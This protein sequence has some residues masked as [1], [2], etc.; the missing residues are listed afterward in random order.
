LAIGSQYVGKFSYSRSTAHW[1]DHRYSCDDPYLLWWTGYGSVCQTTESNPDRY[2]CANAHG[3]Y[4]IHYDRNALPNIYCFS[5]FGWSNRYTDSI[6]HEAANQ[7]ALAHGIAYRNSNTNGHTNIYTNSECH[8]IA[9]T[10]AYK[11]ANSIP[12]AYT[13]LHADDDTLSNTDM[14]SDDY[15]VSNLYGYFNTALNRNSL[16]E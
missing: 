9:D 11:H 8:T 6:R 15:T 16:I 14:D 5:D 10:Y 12:D 1:A 4:A 3:D 2:D 7:H 13:E